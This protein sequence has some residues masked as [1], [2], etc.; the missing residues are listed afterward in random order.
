MNTILSKYIIKSILV[1]VFLVMAVLLSITMLYEFISQ[2]GN[3]QGN[4]GVTEAFVFS[5]LRL[6]QLTFEMLPISILIGSLFCLGMLTSNSELVIIH[7]AGISIKQLAKMLAIGGVFI[8]LFSILLGEF[9]GPS[10]DYYARNMRDEARYIGNEAD[11]GN[12]VWVKDANTIIHL[13][14]V[15]TD[16]DFGSI[17]MF[18]LNDD[19][20]LKSIAVAENS[21]IDA[22]EKWV[23]ENFRETKFEDDK[24]SRSSV[25]LINETFELNS[26]LLGVTLVKPISLSIRE[27]IGYVDY[28]NKN[29]LS[30]NRYEVEL[31]S[32]VSSLLTILTMPILALSFVYSSLRSVGTGT[33]LTAG[34][35]IGLVY[36]LLRELVL[37]YGQVYGFNSIITAWTPPLLLFLFAILRLKRIRYR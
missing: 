31:W 22:N 9:V 27:L 32:R 26:D 1:G 36:F 19:K 25:D 33:R 11:F 30:S 24:V 16:Y 21:G 7:S 15:N 29:D 13:E 34:L 5:L 2:L 18:H 20:S 6:P 14:R 4:F 10:L 28:L 8:A 23:L 12:A 17:Y 3:L 37:N 35:I